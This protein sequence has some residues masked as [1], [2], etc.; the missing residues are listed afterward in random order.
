MSVPDLG[1]PRAPYLQIADDLRRQIKAGRYQPGER[2]PSLPTMSATYGSAAET[3]RR[4]LGK[5]RDEGLVA[6]QSTRGTFVLRRPPDP[7]PGAGEFE[8]A[9]KAAE[10]RLTRHVDNEI[11]KLREELEY[12]Q[13]QVLALGEQAGTPSVRSK[14]RGL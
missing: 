7:D 8:P 6:T 11:A 13:A 9:L 1:D 3:I 4:A 14:G 10:E 2:L 12:T 5:L